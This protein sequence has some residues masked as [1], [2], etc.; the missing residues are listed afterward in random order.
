MMTHRAVT[1]LTA[2][3]LAL[4]A[5]M[6]PQHAEES[7]CTDNSTLM[8]NMGS[9][10][11]KAYIDGDKTLLH[12]EDL[13]SVFFRST[14][15]EKWVYTGEDG[16]TSGYLTVC[17]AQNRTSG[18]DRITALYP[19]SETASI[20]D[21][22]IT[23]TLPQE[24]FYAEG[25]FGRGAAVL[26]AQ[27]SAVHETLNFRYASGF[28]RLRLTGKAEIKDIVLSS[29]GGEALCGACRIDMSTGSPI[30]SATGSSSVLLRDIDFGYISLDGTEDFIFSVAPGTYQ[31][32]VRFDITYTTGQVQTVKTSESFTVT[33]GVL[34]TPV[35][36]IAQPLFTI[37]ASFYTGGTEAASPFDVTLTRDLVPGVT[38]STSESK[39]I[40]LKSDTGKKDPF[41]FYISC[42]DKADNL[43]VTRSGLNFGGTAGDYIL[44]PGIEGLKLVQVMVI[45]SNC[46]VSINSEESVTPSALIH[47]TG[48][49]SG[50]ACK[51]ELCSDTIA[52]IHN[53]ILYYDT[54]L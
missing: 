21:G 16:T 17:D 46:T 31:K 52:R 32:G 43:R 45:G 9:A 10:D 4:S 27:V 54:A 23:T 2:A 12:S 36:A 5:C 28:V 44:L 26:A 47:V 20:S 49:E 40:A 42:K 1:I 41:R 34:A 11:T 13:F 14:L 25:S 15:N 7:L 38:G 51:L 48:A 35:E 39:D 8:V 6:K 30:L 53:L 33:A 22:G 37:E 19:W 29:T 3:V 18:S 50:K 24:Q